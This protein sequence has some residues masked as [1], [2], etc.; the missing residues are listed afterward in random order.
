MQSVNPSKCDGGIT[1]EDIHE[2]NLFGPENCT[3]SGSGR[4]SG[5]PFPANDFSTY[6]RASNERCGLPEFCK[7][8]YGSPGNIPPA[9]NPNGDSADEVIME[10]SGCGSTIGGMPSSAEPGITCCGDN[11]FCSDKDGDGV[12]QCM[13]CNADGGGCT[14]WTGRGIV[15]PRYVDD[16]DE[17]NDGSADHPSRRHKTD[18]GKVDPVT[19]PAMNINGEIWDDDGPAPKKGAGSSPEN[20]DEIEDDSNAPD[21]EKVVRKEEN[22]S[23]DD[24]IDQ[25]E[26]A[27]KDA[28]PVTFQDG[29]LSVDV[30]DMSFPGTRG[31]PL[32]FRRNYSSN[33]GHRGSLGSN[34][35]H[36]YEVRL[37]FIN[38]INAPSWVPPYCT[39]TS[40]TTTCVLYRSANGG[41]QLFMY[42][43]RT[44]VFTP[45]AGSTLTLSKVKSDT[46]KDD[47]T[48]W[49]L[50]SPEGVI[51]G[52]NQYGYLIYRYDRFGNGFRI[53]YETYPIYALWRRYC[54]PAAFD[55]FYGESSSDFVELND[56]C[57]GLARTV[58]DRWETPGEDR[59]MLSGDSQTE[60]RV[61]ENDDL[62]AQVRIE[63]ESDLDY[64]S[65][66]NHVS[67]GRDYVTSFPE[68][69]ELF[70]A[71]TG[72]E[73]LRPT[74]VRDNLGRTLTFTYDDAP[75]ENG[76][77]NPKFGLLTRVDGPNGAFVEFTYD[78]PP[79]APDPQNE[80]FLVG[81]E[82]ETSP[83]I[84][85]P[86]TLDYDYQWSNETWPNPDG[87]TV[88]FYA[89]KV[90][91]HY[92]AY[93]EAVSDCTSST[94]QDNC[95][96]STPAVRRGNSCR[97]AH[98]STYD[99]RSSI[100]D[101]II[102]VTRH[103][104]FGS[105]EVV[106]VESSFRIDPWA[107][108][109]DHVVKQR[110]GG[111]ADPNLSIGNGWNTAYPD[112]HLE[113]Y[114]AGPTDA[115][116]TDRT[117]TLPPEIKNRYPF[118]SLPSSAELNIPYQLEEPSGEPSEPGIAECVDTDESDECQD[119]EKRA[120]RTA[121]PS[122]RPYYDYYEKQSPTLSGSRVVL[123][124]TRLSCDQ[125]ARRQT[126]DALHNDTMTTDGLVK[127]S[128]N[129]SVDDPLNN[130]RLF[131]FAS[132]YCS[133]SWNK[134]DHP[135]DGQVDDICLY[136]ERRFKCATSQENREWMWQKLSE[137]HCRAAILSAYNDQG[138][139]VDPDV[140]SESIARVLQ[141][142]ADQRKF[143]D[144]NNKRICRWVK[145]TDRDGRTRFW[146][147]NYRG[148][149]LVEA[150][151]DQS[152]GKFLFRET[153]YNADGN[154][155]EVRNTAEEGTPS[156]NVGYSEI[157][158]DEDTP[159]SLKAAALEPAY[160]A[161]RNNVESRIQ[162]P[163]SPTSVA[164]EDGSTKTV[165]YRRTSYQYEPLFN[166]VMKTHASVKFQ[167]QPE[168]T[169]RSTERVF[170][171]Q[172]LGAGDEPLDSLLIGML[173][174]GFEWPLRSAADD[175]L[176]VDW[177]NS[178]FTS[179]MFTVDLKDADQ[180]G[181]GVPQSVQAIR[182]RAVGVPVKVT[183]YGKG[184][185]SPRTTV[186][187]W[188]P[189]G[190]PKR[191]ETP[192]GDTAKYS[193]YP[194][195][196]DTSS[197]THFYG[198]GSS[199][200][201]TWADPDN[202]GL[203]ASRHWTRVDDT[204]SSA[205]SAE[206]SLS[207]RF[208]SAC[209]S[210]LGPYG[211][212]AGDGCQTNLSQLNLPQDVENEILETDTDAY[213]EEVFSYGQ[214]GYRTSMWRNSGEYSLDRDNDGRT[215]R[216]D[217]PNGTETTI[218]Y[219]LDGNPT[220]IRV[221]DIGNGTEYR[222]IKREYDDAGHLIRECTALISGGC[223]GESAW[224]PQVRDLTPPIEYQLREHEFALEGLPKKNVDPR[225]V[226]TEYGYVGNRRLVRSVLRINRNATPASSNKLSYSYDVHDRVTGR[227]RGTLS[228][229][230]GTNV[231][232]EYVSYD[233]LGRIDSYVD[234]RQV[235]WYIG[236]DARNN[237]L[238]RTHQPTGDT[239]RHY[240]NYHNERTKTVDNGI[241]TTEYLRTGDGRLAAIEKTGREG[242]LVT[243]DNEGRPVWEMRPD[244]SVVFRTWQPDDDRRTESVVRRDLDGNL[245]TSATV[246]DSDENG[247]PL[248]RVKT[249]THDGTTLSQT[250]T[251]TRDPLGRPTE[252]TRPDGRKTTYELINYAGWAGRIREETPAGWDETN[253]V[254]N[255]AGAKLEVSDAS[256]QKTKWTYT[257]L[258][259]LSTREKPGTT[260]KRQWDYDSLGRIKD[261]YIPS[262]GSGAREQIRYVYDPVTG[263]QTHI[264]WNNA[265]TGL[266]NID[267]VSRSF[268]S[269]GR[270][271]SDSRYNLALVS[272][273]YSAGSV[274][275]YRE[276]DYDAIGR[277][278]RAARRVGTGPLREVSSQY[279]ATS[280]GDSWTRSVT[281]P[282]SGTQRPQSVLNR[283][284]DTAGRVKRVVGSIGNDSVDTDLLWRGDTYV[285]RDQFWGSTQ[286][287]L[288]ESR[289]FDAF[290][291]SLSRTYSAV[292]LDSSG[293]PISSTW[294]DAYCGGSWDPECADPLLRIDM[295]RNV[296]GQIGSLKWSFGHPFIDSQGQL[297][298][299]ETHAAPW[300]G[301]LYDRR[302]SLSAVWEHAGIT[303][304]VDDSTLWS[305]NHSLTNA[306]VDNLG[307]Q[308]AAAE[309][310][311]WIRDTKVGSLSAILDRD[312]VDPPR[313]VSTT[314]NTVSGTTR[315]PGHRLGSVEID[316]T[317][318]V[319][320][321]D[322]AGRVSSAMGM[323][324]EWGPQ[325]RLARV[326]DGTGTLE[327]YL[328]DADG[329]LTA[330]KLS[331]S[332]MLEEFVYDGDQMV[333]AFDGSAN[334][335]WEAVWGGKQDQLLMWHDVYSGDEGHIPLVDH[336][337]S[338][339]AT[340]DK[341]DERIEELARY[342][343]QGRLTLK[344]FKEAPTCQEPGNP[345]TICGNP[346]GM[347]F[348][349]NS[350]YRSGQTGFVY[351][352]NRW[353]A[354]RLGQLLSH[355]PLGYVDS[356]NLYAYVAF[357]P[358]NGWDPYGL[359]NQGF[360]DP[361]PGIPTRVVNWVFQTTREGGGVEQ[362]A[363]A[364]ADKNR[365]YVRRA[366]RKALEMD[367]IGGG[368][369]FVGV[370]IWEKL[371]PTSGEE[372]M[373]DLSLSVGGG[374]FFKGVL[375]GAKGANAARKMARSSRNLEWAEDVAQSGRRSGDDL[376]S[377]CSGGRCSGKGVP[378]FVASTEVRMCDGSTTNIERIDPGDRV[379]A[380]NPRT[381]ET[382]CR[383]VEDTTETPH[384][385]ILSLQ[386]RAND[387]ATQTF[388]VTGD[389]PFWTRQS[390]WTDASELKPG[391]EV[392]TSTG[393][394]ADVLGSN[395][396]SD[397]Q[398]VYNL[399]V[400]RA[401]TYFVGEPAVWV[402]NIG[403][404]VDDVLKS[405]RRPSR[406]GSNTPRGRQS[407]QKKVD[408]GDSAY[409]GLDKTQS[410]AED[411][412]ENT[413]SSNRAYRESG[414]GDQVDVFNP[415]T[416]R[417]V[418][419]I[420]GSN[421]F[422][423]FL[424]ESQR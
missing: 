121:L 234:S 260:T 326:S 122:W 302:G 387:T 289:E 274:E 393:R 42:D 228:A 245:W 68:G 284:L 316:Q 152:R 162:H 275:V 368:A 148:Q 293:Q 291:R 212:L 419:V 145:T 342:T 130:T 363:E 84:G 93:H 218:T 281:Y 171:Y 206:S 4:V 385:R 279:V 285:G 28:D 101:N 35:R 59:T 412:I 208:G 300:R 189:N 78:T 232:E 34:W 46:K 246:T 411:I 158:Y 176:D 129:T 69:S 233:D 365:E 48:E 33:S 398:T 120:L 27:K 169:L 159:S 244:G 253:F 370:D 231:I 333:A 61:P 50:R 172:E 330:I 297:A 155:T 82:R 397:R 353:Y 64:P 57:A 181:N 72:K 295:V 413:L 91:Q 305:L 217:A 384:A 390:G 183:Q 87:A 399:S 23:R 198:D 114:D 358:I 373:L 186:L 249:G 157:E 73:K 272:M 312:D 415:E 318:Y 306:D 264:R 405:S 44:G 256:G 331:P 3:E 323:T 269:K 14:E 136:R 174:W 298:T 392:Y 382:G 296:I 190:R 251:W 6:A 229:T 307:N 7:S 131:R 236:Q 213:N 241:L 322:Q 144:Q 175:T 193:Y 359:S 201:D 423:T 119:A 361:N 29:S 125:L 39:S 311:D 315:A 177:S 17:D 89:N 160:W 65:Y 180:N 378:C 222:H 56:L 243:Y 83:A 352:R 100:R 36:N 237:V 265:P 196:A 205:I 197:T 417:G 163:K 127:V 21:A 179:H 45:Q 332:V 105:S 354:P 266:S 216:V 9:C 194:S 386:I 367:S 31:S 346:S 168:I 161:R 304:P 262:T 141:F 328:Y 215:Y 8:V 210:D 26:Q 40:P 102:R 362:T 25:K 167:Q 49:L 313:W 184:M 224:M 325:G 207:S 380:R 90:Y 153:L 374:I 63:Y 99:Y 178:D 389:H 277:V 273:G 94:I 156:T 379:L 95:T 106:E 219:S 259:R 220:E 75:T 421:E 408:R 401:H 410:K 81:A 238:Y 282:A 371:T 278:T 270:V 376:A 111:R 88:D 12:S 92:L 70:N 335:S 288:R 338:V 43:R 11:C 248:N 123:K 404:D 113:Y 170:D 15:D 351:M 343:A 320:S 402:H 187:R 356:Y 271:Q 98:F 225:G 5:A 350:Q 230:S 79:S 383:T 314:S 240:Y 151:D 53:E 200:S 52:F 258:G 97:Y 319:L 116:G 420:E 366:K 54:P 418:R 336:R 308:Y 391:D 292:D 294:G 360:V 195:L 188:A 104:G 381:K 138:E 324:M 329:K 290:G 1:A 13:D 142:D 18:S 364:V 239:T 247:Q 339:V 38:K 164:V 24:G 47:K 396:R 375:K 117:S 369:L 71:P 85:T 406:P 16:V 422:V 19:F 76:D 67:S 185:N 199:T 261:V 80:A 317:S 235:T 202:S 280:G 263:D 154:A 139:V 143:I 372:A 55:R 414:P 349:F 109:F 203:L 166:Q 96:G 140:H 135:L 112:Y 32:Q 37:E 301:Y 150:F 182:E 337:N 227:F 299:G 409:Q 286:D 124:R 327:V 147:L 62:S 137:S 400:A 377:N 204:Y 110:Y 192:H 310:W 267:L 126:T 10:A 209:R 211:W 221:D 22:P 355:D 165:E 287:P 250:E 347:P 341:A 103:E 77:P 242:R 51:W 107:I 2:L 334:L 133:T 66:F 309:A 254:R 340:W 416:G 74:E 348:G 223:N 128:S 276:F 226:N 58:N 30:T 214:T 395:W 344:D 388:G 60:L 191:I 146:G 132:D 20:A 149:T 118:E 134:S 424:N 41:V 357:D 108:D 403:C 407:L 255:P 115:T 303:N 394:W 345:G 321:H 283:E 257:P 252:Y 173:K 86:R 268:D